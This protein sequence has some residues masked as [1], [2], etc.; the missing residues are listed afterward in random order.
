MNGKQE[1]FQKTDA[2]HEVQKTGLEQS[3]V[4]QEANTSLISNKENKNDN[5]NNSGSNTPSEDTN[6][7]ENVSA[8]DING[9]LGTSKKRDAL[10]ENQ[11]NDSEKESLLTNLCTRDCDGTLICGL[12]NARSASNKAASIIELIISQELFQ[13]QFIHI[14]NSV[15]NY[16]ILLQNYFKNYEEV[17]KITKGICKARE[18]RRKEKREGALGCARVR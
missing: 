18:K 6:S 8:L 16:K 14:H 17:V 2:P 3:T 7:I 11:L 15:S 1:E 9:N 4:I 10:G 5:D 13:F 12:I